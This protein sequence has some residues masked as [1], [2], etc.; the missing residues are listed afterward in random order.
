MGIERRIIHR[1][2]FLSA[3]KTSPQLMGILNVTPDSFSDG[4]RHSDLAAA[5]AHA[6]TMVADGAA[7][8]DV[9]GESTRPGHVPVPEDEELRRVVPALEALGAALD[10]PISIDTS[11]AAVA[12]EAARLGACVINDVWG[13]QRDPG[14]AD[15]VAET[16]SAVVVMHNRDAADPAIDILDDVE[17]FFERSLN[18]AAGAGVPFGRILL[19][20]GVGFG[21]TRQQNHACIW[22]L[23][24]FRRLGAPILVG[25]SRKSFIGGIIDA[26]VDRRLPG[27]LAAD[28]IALMRGASVLRVHD[29]IE[30]RAALAV[31][32]AL[33]TAA[34]P[35]LTGESTDDGKARFALALGGNVGDKA[36][37]LRRALRAIANE[38]GV[39]LTAASRLYRTAPWGKTDQDWFVNACA[40]G[41]TT[42]APEALLDRVK[43]L[44]VELGRE[45]TER[46][47]PR[48]IDIDLIAYDDVTLKTERLTLP[49]PELFNRAFV[50]VPLAEIAS[51]LVIAGV[52][53]GD[54]AA[55]LGAEAA[56]ILP[57]D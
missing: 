50:L 35:P 40:L 19:D 4:G 25:L 6:K 55:R 45:P 17:R 53:V 13:L 18:L 31:F 44:E 29:V 24:R 22:N 14:M 9:G 42:L 34:T 33:K 8:V 46:W 7:I 47:G 27:T 11:K 39:E 48:V 52:R 20:P 54:A 41:R 15:A 38:S 36:G 43:K 32:M 5:V 28:T 57:L 12:R 2:K 51:D 16:G 10:A 21:K 23:D 30:N 56:E 1:D 49:H 26:E 3:L 37:S